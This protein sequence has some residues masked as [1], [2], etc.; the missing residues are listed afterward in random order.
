MTVKELI[1]LLHDLPENL[2]VRSG[3]YTNS[4]IDVAYIDGDYVIIE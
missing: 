4:D 2:V 3:D 1:E